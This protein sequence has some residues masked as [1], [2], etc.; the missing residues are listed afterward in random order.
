[1]IEQ[2][3]FG[4]RSQRPGSGRVEVTVGDDV[5]VGLGVTATSP[6]E[7]DGATAS[8]WTNV[9][10]GDPAVFREVPMIPV[11]PTD[12]HQ[13]AFEVTLVAP[14]ASAVQKP[15]RLLV[16]FRTICRSAV[17]RPMIRG[18]RPSGTSCHRGEAAGP[19]GAICQAWSITPTRPNRCRPSVTGSPACSRRW[20]APSTC[21]P[22]DGR[23][24]GSG[25]WSSRRQLT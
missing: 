3:E 7:L 1:V 25:P 13:R 6:A 14:P 15:H 18:G 17:G 16:P 4:G 23:R 12:H 8:L 10:I 20:S 21:S 11:V 19:N 22:A 9:G 2:V 24:S 5:T